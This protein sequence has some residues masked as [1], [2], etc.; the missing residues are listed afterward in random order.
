MDS[1]VVHKDSFI[2]RKQNRNWKS[3]L[4]SHVQLLLSK[5]LCPSIRP[6][7]NPSVRLFANAFAFLPITWKQMDRFLPIFVQNT[8][9]VTYLA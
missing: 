5:S 1:L 2:N 3:N 4:L 9:H 8:E 7:V 6:S